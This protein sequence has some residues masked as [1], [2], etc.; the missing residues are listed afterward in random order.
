MS[1]SLQDH[2]ALWRTLAN[3][4]KAGT[5]LLSGLQH[6]RSKLQKS[7]LDRVIEHL[8]Q[9]ISEG[10]SLSEAM[11]PHETVFSHCVRTMV[12][13]GEAGGVLEVICGRIAEG[14]QDGSF[15]PA[16]APARDDDPARYWRAFGRLI[17]SGVPILQALDL[18][19]LEVAGP[20]LAEPT[21]TIRQAIL[22]GEDM[23]TT[24]A[25]MPDLFPD[26]VRVAV[27][28]GERAGDLDRQAFRIAEA[29]EARDLASLVPDPQ[30][31]MTE[32]EANRSAVV[33][34]TNLMIVQAFKQRA[35]DIHLDSTEDGRGR[36]RL[37]IDGVL[38]DIEPPPEG[39]FPKIVG[40]IKIMSNMDIAERRRPQ[41][42]R[43]HIDLEGRKLDLRVSCVPTALGPRIVMRIFDRES[44]CIDLERIGLL[45]DDL[46][47]VRGLCHLPHGI[48]ICNGPT[49]S[50]KTTLLYSMLNEIDREK[51]CVMSVED[52]VEYH[53][54]GV[55][56]IQVDAGV[57]LTFVRALR[58]I[59][60]QDPD[61]IM[62]GEIRDLDTLQAAAQ[63]SLT[64][65]LIL[66][67]LHANSSPGA[68]RRLLDAGLEPF[69]VNATLAG[70]I[71]QRLVRVLCLECKRPAPPSLHSIPP[72]AIEFIQKR[73]DAAF[74]APKGCEAC[75][76]MGYRG[77]TAIHEILVPDDRVREAVAASA[78]LAGLRNAALAAGM[79]P[80]LLCGLEKAA[81]GITSLQEVCRV[82]PVG[83]ND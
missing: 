35:S 69:L 26:E 77:R 33:K 72:A 82:A 10:S 32:D 51:C 20:K 71:S 14:L 30:M 1:L 21:R 27:A 83:P 64:G 57:G 59:L 7:D 12:R 66:T 52:P 70:V 60:R 39:L 11:A 3:E 50:G 79:R 40:R 62:V 68:V 46:A 16:G 28:A 8:I 13:A 75:K 41:D 80:M 47:T 9:D 6:A 43:I 63:C 36:V 25:A 61:V 37:R 48:L 81:R 23:A 24:L 54:E 34:A 15:P 78:D 74:Y 31:T 49:G 19:A 67:T 55:G 73:P 53:L 29:L 22:D 42:G 58:S 38:H 5:P 18:L 4:L 56:Q 2:L 17:S 76:G 65:H 45:E 44:V